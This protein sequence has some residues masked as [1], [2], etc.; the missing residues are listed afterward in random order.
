MKPARDNDT[1]RNLR[2]AFWV[3]V[4]V[5]LI[6]LAAAFLHHSNPNLR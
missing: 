4:S 1:P 2:I 6:F 3:A 5:I